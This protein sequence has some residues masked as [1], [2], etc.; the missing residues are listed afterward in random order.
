MS[1]R[2]APTSGL[3]SR[4]G[5]PDR[6]VQGGFLLLTAFASTGCPWN[7]AG[8]TGCQ[9][10][11]VARPLPE[12]LSESSGVAWSLA[13]PGILFSHNDG[14]DDPVIYAMDSQGNLQARIPLEGAENRDWE[15][16][17][18]ARC[19]K[20]N[21]IYLADT[22]DNYARW[23]ESYLY[24][25]VDTG[26][27][28]ET[29]RTV[30]RYPMILPDGTRDIEALFVLP[31]EVVHLITKGRHEGNTL[32]RYPPPL[33]PGEAVTLE[34]VQTLSEGAMPIP[35]QIT[36]A[37]ASEDG[38]IVVVRSYQNMTFYRVEDGLLIPIE[39]GTVELGTLAEPQGEGVAIGPDGLLILTT[40]AGSFGGVASMQLLECG[41]LK[42]G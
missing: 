8:N 18:T 1:P 27:L 31:G 4:R 24:R 29:P 19:D 34:K 3:P 12:L 23:S 36:G 28:D 35:S 2:S 14:G 17:A 39:E 26:S 41:V 16:M 21:C 15:D 9:P 40:E 32:Y 42:G 25:I 10:I 33:R 30:E 7:A 20:G 11:E 22:G 38:K 6:W 5:L 37:D 13:R